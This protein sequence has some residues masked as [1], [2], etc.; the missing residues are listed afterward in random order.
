[1]L[2]APHE[3]KR[4]KQAENSANVGNYLLVGFSCCDPSIQ[5]NNRHKA[6]QADK[7]EL[8]GSKT[9]Q[10]IIFKLS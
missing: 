8:I 3:Q 2:Q 6:C 10:I 7:H 9:N 4:D 5:T 1:M